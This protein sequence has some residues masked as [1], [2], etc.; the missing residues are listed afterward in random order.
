M[1]WF[2]KKQKN[3]QKNTTMA[4]LQEESD[5]KLIAVLAAAVSAYLGIKNEGFVIRS[6]KKTAEWK[7]S[8]REMQLFR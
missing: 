2:Q 4:P 8:A 6:Y 3:I 5:G 1:A 7:R